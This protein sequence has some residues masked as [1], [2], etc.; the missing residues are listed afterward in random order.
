MSYI[1]TMVRDDL[2][3]VYRWKVLDDVYGVKAQGE[4]TDYLE[5]AGNAEAAKAALMAG[6]C[7]GGVC[8]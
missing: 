7:P 3:S 8:G 4:H 2:A 6:E 5:A 1:I